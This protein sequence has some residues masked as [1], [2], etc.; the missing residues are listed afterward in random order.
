MFVAFAWLFH[1]GQVCLSLSRGFHV[2]QMLRV[3]ALENL[4]IAVTILFDFAFVRIS[5]RLL[6]FDNSVQLGAFF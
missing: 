3:L 5:L 1:F 4:L 6:A 2:G